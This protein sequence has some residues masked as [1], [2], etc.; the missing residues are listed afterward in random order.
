MTPNRQ[1]RVVSSQARLEA[2]LPNSVQAVDSSALPPSEQDRV[3]ALLRQCEDVFSTHD[4]D[5]VCTDLITHEI[6]LQD[7]VPVCQRFMRIPPSEY[8]AG[9][10]HIRQLLAR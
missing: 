7:E 5:L 10:A 3:W 4:G 1:V 6:T 2:P 9:K 8:E